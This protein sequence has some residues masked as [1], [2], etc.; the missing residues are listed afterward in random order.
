MTNSK[1]KKNKA[2]ITIFVFTEL[3]F[4]KQLDKQVLNFYTILQRMS[5]L[6]CAFTHA[7]YNCRSVR[8]L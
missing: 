3:P 8:Y 6:V 7:I 4:Q 1:E 5:Q 2:N